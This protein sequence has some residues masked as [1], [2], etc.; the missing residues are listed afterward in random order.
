MR[1]RGLGV[2]RVMRRKGAHRQARAGAAIWVLMLVAGALQS[3]PAQGRALSTV[4]P[5]PALDYSTH[6]ACRAP[7]AGRARCLAL[8]LVPRTAAARAHNHPLGMARRV[9]V[10]AVKATEACEPPTAAGGCYGLRPG[11]IHSGYGLPTT[12][13]SPQTIALVNAYNDPNAEADLKAYDEEFHLPACTAANGCFVRV[14]EN[15]RTNPLPESNAGWALEISLDIEVAHAICQSCRIVLVEAND[16]TYP[17]L[18][19][20]EETAASRLGAT[21]ISNSWGGQEP[22]ADSGVF[23]RPGVVITAASGDY[24]YRNWDAPNGIEHNYVSYPA[25]S[26]HVVAVGGTRLDLTPEGVWAGEMVWNDGSTINGGYGASGGGCSDLFT[27]PA[28]QKALADWS[29]VGCESKRAIAD[30]SADADPY[31]GAAVYDST[32]IEGRSGWRSIGGTS[33]ASPLIASVFALAGGAGGVEYPA[34]TLYENETRAPASLHDVSSGSNGECMKSFDGTTGLS[35]CS[36]AEEAQLSCTETAI[37]LAG[38]GY[39]GPSGVGSPDG[40]GA[41]TAFSEVAKRSQQIEFTSVAPSSAV[42]GGAVYSVAATAS[43]GLAVSFSSYTPATCV[44]AESIVRMVAVGT[45]TIDAN[46]LGDGEYEAAPQAQQSFQ[47][48]RST[49]TITFTSSPPADGDTRAYTEVHASAT[50]GLT[51]GFRSETPSVCEVRAPTETG[52]LIGYGAAGTCTIDAFQNGNESYEAAAEV[53][54]SFSVPGVAQIIQWI[55]NPPSSATLKGP[56]YDVEATATSGLAVSFSS[57]TPSVCS[58]EP[59]GLSYRAIVTYSAAGTCTVDADQA[60]NPVYAAAPELQQSFPVTKRAQRIEFI[61]HAPG[62][63]TVAGSSYAVSV[64]ASSGLPVSL[65]SVTP[66]VCVLTGS[67]VSFVA[68]GTCTLAATQAGNVEFEP[69]LE[70]QQSFTVGKRLQSIQFTSS[71]PSS[72]TLG[73]AGYT[74]TAAASSGLPV[75]LSSATPAVCSV[76]GSTV[77]FVGAGAC[78]IDANQAGSGE[79]GAAPQAEQSFSVAKR[80]QLITFT[81]SAPSTAS[82]AGAYYTVSATATSGLPVLYFSGTPSVCVVADATVRLIDA[83]ACTVEA[84]QSGNGE[85]AAAPEEQQSFLVGP[86][87]VFAYTPASALQV[88]SLSATAT[89]TSSSGDLTVPTPTVNV[90]THNAQ[91]KYVR[92]TSSGYRLIGAGVQARFSRAGVTIGSGAKR[93]SMTLA[94]IRRGTHKS[95]LTAVR[96]HATGNRVSFKHT[97][98][99]EWYVAGALGMEQ[100]FT[101]TRRP[102][103][104]GPLTLEVSLRGPL[105]ARRSGSGLELTG[106][107]GAT[108]LRYGELSASDASGRGLRAWL[109][110]THSRLLIHVEDLHTRYPLRIDPFLQQG[111]PLSPV[112]EGEFGSSV[113]VSAD[114]NT[115]LIGNR[116]GKEG[117]SASVFTRSGSTWTQQDEKL[118]GTGEMPEGEF[119]WHVALSADGNTALVG[120]PAENGRI[121]GAWVFTRS[122][123]IW[124]QQGPELTGG[125]ETGEGRF[126][127]SVAL[128]ADGNTALIGGDEDYGGAGAAWVFTRS[129]STWTQEGPKLLASDESAAEESMLGASVALSADGSTALIGGWG[130]STVQGAAWV[131]TRSGSIWTQQGKKLAVGGNSAWFGYSVALSEDGNTALV[132]A[133]QA[134]PNGEAWVFTRS[135]STWTGD[136]ELT[137]VEGENSYSRLGYS[138]ALNGDGNM[139]LIGAPWGSY[140]NNGTGWVFT[141]SGSIWTRQESQVRGAVINK[142]GQRF[143]SSVALSSTG[144]TALVGGSGAAWAQTATPEISAASSVSFGSQPIGQ[145]GAVQWLEVT[146]AGNA[147]IAPLTFTSAAQI[148]GADASDFAIPNGDDLCDGQSIMPGQTCRIGVQFTA[149]TV[150]ER[151]ATLTFGAN[152]GPS[153]APTVELTGTGIGPDA[154]FSAAPNPGTAQMPV[155]FTAAGSSDS[156]GVLESYTWSFGDGSSGQGMTPTHIYA[157]P[158]LYTVK[159]SV[160]GSGGLTSTV[161]HVVSIREAQQ[162]RFTSTASSPATVGGAPYTLSATASSG[163]AVGFS[164]ATPTICST[165]GS[166]VSFVGVGTCTIDADQAGDSAYSPAPELVQSFAVMRS[167][168]VAFYSKAPAQAGMGGAA[169]WVSAASSSGLAVVFSSATPAVC[170]VS[171][172]IVSFIGVGTCT[173]DVDQAGNSEYEPAQQ[174]QQTF[175]VGKDSQRIAILSSPPESASVGGEAHVL[176]VASSGLAVSFSSSTPSVCSVSGSTVS[177]IAV[178]TCMID[179]DQAGDSEYNAASRAQQSFTVAPRP[180]LTSQS[181]LISSLVPTP[182][183]DFT[184]VAAP[185]TNQK[186]GSIT[187]SLKVSDPGTLSWLVAFQSGQHAR[188]RKVRRSVGVCNAGEVKI[189]GV[190]SVVALVFGQ[191]SKSVADPGV[192]TFT[193]APGASALLVLKRSATLFVTATLTFQSS[194]GGPSESQ[195]RSVVVRLAKTRPKRGS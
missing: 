164:S 68:V 83:G 24:G 66:S 97:G 175:P 133:P 141:C 115:A 193:V 6:S 13:S 26:P 107:S 45:C 179:A 118:N 29:S 23:D 64:S 96:P 15:G 85:Y 163:L 100:G 49:Q 126:G 101:V 39:D 144:D 138:V 157:A 129:G 25:A 55:S 104:G 120:A 111:E 60:G 95:A 182:N 112:A 76:S 14:N 153:A 99:V 1:G 51:V 21:E 80:S 36:V 86:A 192:V 122:G 87:L 11:D 59:S 171:G 22:V 162:L 58:V 75:S 57:A 35:A 81:S 121:G 46:Q 167:Q 103:G 90:P 34:R 38:G 67:T 43:S 102:P 94:A 130:D 119:G 186:A 4:A 69:A 91:G 187:F 191:A 89:Q 37:C 135:G 16:E 10:G 125:G 136:Q 50:S 31:T 108:V 27:A 41:F 77:S 140:E 61:L 12:A 105:Q 114:G 79:Y 44:V 184:L 127:S 92:H 156:D 32:P 173:V 137:L 82:V 117:G 5:L 74:V 148:S 42:A 73:G 155:D 54:Q 78:A 132:G 9:R 165:S 166:T 70:A 178:G 33:L 8:E 128:S 124:A 189:N 72:A 56:V 172:S 150:G 88:S 161:T 53:Q 48:G 7:S 190:C 18:E 2:V 63:A 28:W 3:L 65:S 17:S 20:A 62:S 146:N 47:I 142:A 110:L 123:S 113:A 176:A 93:L 116:Y 40:L 160:S 30:V 170:S 134:Y 154:V 169:Y 84:D 131:F 195:S 180:I 147:P 168:A 185:S 177:L 183:S 151:T 139:A 19:A 52:A 143:G 98:V 106:A 194:L 174:A 145:P 152:N 71:P 109:S 159:L 149:A 181:A 158:G 188:P